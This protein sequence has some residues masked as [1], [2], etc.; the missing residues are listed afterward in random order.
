MG[1]VR[2][3]GI[4]EAPVDVVFDYVD[5]PASVPHWMFGV[6]RFDPIGSVERGVGSRFAASMRVGPKTL[7]STVVCSEWEKDKLIVL[8]SADGLTNSSRWEFADLGDG[9]TRMSVVF[10]YT[11]PG[12]IA[13]KM[14]GALVTPF[15][16]EAVKH[17]EASLRKNLSEA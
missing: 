9:T 14:L 5:D 2:H 17:S 12:G 7:H 4:A 3:S 13:G 15:V 6:S 1:T 10:D 11:L 16:A 8:E